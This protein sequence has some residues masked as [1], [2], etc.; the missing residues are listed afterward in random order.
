MP[1]AY[2]TVDVSAY[3]SVI[4]F[5]DG[6]DDDYVELELSPATS[7]DS[8]RISPPARKGKR[9]ISSLKRNA[10]KWTGGGSD[11]PST[12]KSFS[13]SAMTTS[14]GSIAQC[15][16]LSWLA[17]FIWWGLHEIERFTSRR[18]LPLQ[19]GG[20]RGMNV[21]NESWSQ[22]LHLR[23]KQFATNRTD[24]SL[25]HVA[26]YFKSYQKAASDVMALVLGS[27]E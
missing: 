15:A 1:D 14:F 25:C 23:A 10:F 7:K 6:L 27:G 11:S 18:Y 26:A 3:T 8:M 17:Q 9:N 19:Q 13:F 21:G 16:L 4:D 5:D 22:R 2:R 12:V 20:F 24:L